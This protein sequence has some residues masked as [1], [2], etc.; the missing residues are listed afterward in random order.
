MTPEQAVVGLSDLVDT[1]QRRLDVMRNAARSAKEQWEGLGRA[2]G[3]RADHAAELVAAAMLPDL[4]CL[5]SYCGR[6]VE[7]IRAMRADPFGKGE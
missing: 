2:G 3:Q 4:H 5:S 7:Q 1:L 6:C